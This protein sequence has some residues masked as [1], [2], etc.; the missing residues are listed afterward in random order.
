MRTVAYVVALLASGMLSAQATVVAPAQSA[1]DTLKEQFRNRLGDAEESGLSTSGIA[2]MLRS[3]VGLARDPATGESGTIS[4]IIR[5]APPPRSPDDPEPAGD[6]PPPAQPEPVTPPAPEFEEITITA[7]Q[8]PM[9]AIRIENADIAARTAA[10]RVAEAKQLME[11]AD[12]WPGDSRYADK[13]R[14]AASDKLDDAKAWENRARYILNDVVSVA[15]GEA[16]ARPSQGVIRSAF[17]GGCKEADRACVQL[18]TLGAGVDVATGEYADNVLAQFDTGTLPVRSDFVVASRGFDPLPPRELPNVVDAPESGPPTRGPPMNQPEILE[19]EDGTRIELELLHEAITAVDPEMADTPLFEPC[20]DHDGAC[21]SLELLR[22]FASPEM[23]EALR[24]VAGVALEVTFDLLSVSGIAEFRNGM[25]LT[26]VEDPVLISLQSLYSAV[27]PFAQS[28][29]WAQLP[30]E[31][32]YPGNVERLIGFVLDPEGDDVV[33]VGRAARNANRR[34]DIDMIVLALRQSWRDGKTMGVSLDP[35]EE[36]LGGPQ[37]ARVVNT[38]DDSVAARTML[39]AD[40]AMKKLIGVGPNAQGG[41]TIDISASLSD[42]AQPFLSRFWLVPRRLGRSAIQLSPSGRTVLIGTNVEVRTED[43]LFSGGGL[44]G[45]GERASIFERWAADFNADYQVLEDSDT[46]EPQGVFVRLHGLVDLVVIAKILRL[47]SIE[48]GVL[49]AFSGLPYRR[50]EGTEAVPRYYPGVARTLSGGDGSLWL[51][52]GGVTLESRQGLRST[53]RYDDPVS[54]RLEAAVDEQRGS[55]DIARRLPLAIALPASTNTVGP[56][57]DAALLAGERALARR[58]FDTAIQRFDE[59]LALDYAASTAH[60]GRARA[61]L[62]QSR[63]PEAA[64]ALSRAMALAP[65]DAE[66]HPLMLDILWRQEPRSAFELFDD[67]EK[68]ELSRHYTQLAAAAYRRD[69]IDDIARLADW[70]RDLWEGNG[71]AHMI[72]RLSRGPAEERAKRNDVVRAI[73]AYRGQLGAG[74]QEAARPLAIALAVSSSERLARGGLRLAAFLTGSARGQ[75]VD[76][77]PLITDFERAQE[78]AREA[79]EL[80]DRLPLAPA[81]D[82]VAQAWLV[83]VLGEQ[84][85]GMSYQAALALADQTVTRFPDHPTAVALRAEIRQLAGDPNGALA[86]L[87]HAIGMAPALAAL[88]GKRAL[89]NVTLGNCTNARADLEATFRLSPPHMEIPQ[90]FREIVAGC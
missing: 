3:K 78:E 18:L 20:E 50:L 65:N 6:T 30:L 90:Q 25:D 31:L 88:Y 82:A 70:A 76:P 22:F 86:D 84:R 28:G 83:A 16:P 4:I 87:D 35:L 26:L 44:V 67:E 64:S 15:R 62:E 8:Q 49:T 13:L 51:L 7:E 63:F 85:P 75:V 37:Y 89:I 81:F 71:H 73:R 59:A 66:L 10:S 41:D 52:Q 61:F 42:G 53:N 24:D 55:S 68:Q 40:Y 9:A 11:Q 74:D 79:A 69:Q 33:L 21:P 19:F 57:A 27:E 72:R 54:A 17:G 1:S 56:D 45:T 39:N 14:A 12:A 58:E 23:L 29:Q 5:K 46:V 36:D 60:A 48:Y 80:D 47:N 32:R 34:L 2:A 38:P 77:A 43:I